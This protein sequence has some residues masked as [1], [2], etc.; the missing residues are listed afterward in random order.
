VKIVVT[1]GA[2]FIGSNL[3]EELVNEH[4]VIVYDDFSFGKMENLNRIKDKVQ[5]LK[6]DI[7]DS[8]IKSLKCDA[9]VHLAG[10]SSAPMFM[11][12][13]S[14]G[15]VTNVDGFLNVM[16]CARKNDV[17]VVYA[18][19]S[20]IYGNNPT[21]LTENQKVVPP[22][23]YSVSKLAMENIAHLYNQEFGIE[24]AGLRFMSVYGPH[25]RA[26]GKFAN[27]VSQ[28]MWWM[29]KGENPVIYGDGT[30]TRDF[31][32]VKDIVQAIKLC[33][34][35][36]GSEIYNVGT[37]AAYSLNQLVEILND[38]MGLSIDPTYVENPI[39]NYIMTQ[40]A[41]ITKIGKI[42]YKPEYTLKKG[43]EECYK[44]YR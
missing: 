28:F 4:E 37:G 32:Y 34:G 26:K 13:P 14:K 33:L 21:P 42:G 44:F 20:S 35:V 39:K 16:E 8:K 22:N 15:V 12:D 31:I 10:T 40:L 5:V 18:S 25:E 30:Q 17:K 2:G 6:G 24:S 1:G 3:C 41:D 38:V 19:T 43:I 23:F 7:A 27:L 29:L 11:P 36:K 9:I